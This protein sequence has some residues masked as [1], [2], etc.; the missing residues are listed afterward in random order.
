[1]SR[2]SRCR[3]LRDV[4]SATPRART[5]CAGCSWIADSP[6]HRA[7]NGPAR[8]GAPARRV[9]HPLSRGPRRQRRA[10]RTSRDPDRRRPGN[11]RRSPIA[12]AHP[13]V[14]ARHLGV[15]AGARSAVSPLEEPGFELVAAPGHSFDHHV[16]WDA[17]TGRC[18]AAT[19]I[20]GVKVR[21]AH[22]GEDPRVLARTLRR[23]P[24]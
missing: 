20:L 11:A 17:D 9:P 13:V 18:S 1:M 16:V 5:S 8:P 3:A 14:P 19:S 2:G 10:G 6:R 4:P 15:H 7:R 23:S 22:G 24:R 12:G 21:I